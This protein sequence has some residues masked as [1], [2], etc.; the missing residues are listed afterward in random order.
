MAP[1]DHFL[2]SFPLTSLPF[3]SLLTAVHLNS[4]QIGIKDDQLQPA[5]HW[6]IE[7]VGSEDAEKVFA[8]FDH[9][10][11]VTDDRLPAAYVIR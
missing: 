11:V 5:G 9:E 3:P 7:G 10:G 6:M 4:D 2:R 8:L 1:L